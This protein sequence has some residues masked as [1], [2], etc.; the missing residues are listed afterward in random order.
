MSAACGGHGPVGA[1]PAGCA[2]LGP[3][4][5]SRQGSLL[6]GGV[7]DGGGGRIGLPP[8]C[9]PFVQAPHVSASCWHSPGA[10]TATGMRRLG[11]EGVPSPP[12]P[13]PLPTMPSGPSSCSPWDPLK[14]IAQ[15]EQDGVLHTLQRETQARQARFVG[16]PGPRRQVSTPKGPARS[17]LSSGRGRSD[18][19]VAA[20]CNH[21]VLFLPVPC[22][23]T[24]TP[25]PAGPPVAQH[26]NPARQA[27]QDPQFSVSP[28]VQGTVPGNWPRPAAPR[29]APV[30]GHSTRACSTGEEAES[31]QPGTCPGSRRGQACAQRH[32]CQAQGAAGGRAPDTAAAQVGP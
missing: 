26:G 23:V 18:A 4:P 11:Y 8:P 16:S 17:I 25:T 7:S 14:D 5:E 19:G 3:G 30:G 12:G 10:L 6:P 32:R 29:A 13:P 28:S 9:W 31:E 15:F 27:L 1:G 22:L 21:A 24:L 2:A 20:I